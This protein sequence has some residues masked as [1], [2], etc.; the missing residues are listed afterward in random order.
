MEK[1]FSVPYK[2]ASDIFGHLLFRNSNGQVNI[3]IA[4]SP[5]KNDQE[6]ISNPST[7]DIE[8]PN[9]IVNRLEIE[10]LFDVEDFFHIDEPYVECVDNTES[11]VLQM[12]NS[13]IFHDARIE[14][15]DNMDDILNND[16]NQ[17]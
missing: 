8:E 17:H 4:S 7:K 5:P 14:N 11:V 1:V 6:I 3:S 15:Y 13:E 9:S 16:M 2:V 12:M 10:E